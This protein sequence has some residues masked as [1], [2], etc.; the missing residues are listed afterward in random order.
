MLLEIVNLGTLVEAPKEP[1]K[2]RLA[3]QLQQRTVVSLI[4]AEMAEDILLTL[5]VPLIVDGTGRRRL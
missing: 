5:L 3:L 2:S 4:V 1:W